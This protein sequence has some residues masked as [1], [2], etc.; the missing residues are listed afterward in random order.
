ME[1]INLTP[2]PVTCGAYRFPSAGVA[3]VDASE[4]QAGHIEMVCL[5]HPDD[6]E[7]GCTGKYLPI[8]RQTLGQ[9]SGLPAPRG[10]T[11]YIVSRMVAAA[12]PGRNLLVPARL[13]RDEAGRVV[14]C[15][16]F[17]VLS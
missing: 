13:V 4:T 10:G 12:C 17:E 11:R 16:A 2:H 6:P 1:I 5:V 3:R 9:V 15:S 8:I 7:C 14:G